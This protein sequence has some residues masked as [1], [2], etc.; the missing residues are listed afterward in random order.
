MN[1]PVSVDV[2]CVG[3]AVF[4]LVFAIDH[5]PFP[6]EKC[7]A[8]ALLT[9]G[10]GP[11]ANAAVTAARLG[12]RS[13]FAGYLGE[14]LFGEKHFQE[15]ERERVD[16]SLLV[17]GSTP[18]PLASIL[19]KP[20]GTRAVVNYR[21][22]TELVQPEK[23][24]LSAVSPKVILFDGHEH[25]ISLPLALEAKEQGILTVLDAGSV[26]QGTEELYT[27]VDYVVSSKTFALEHTNKDSADRA[28]EVL[29]KETSARLVITQGETGLSYWDSGTAMHM[30][31]FKVKASDTTG[32]GD[33]FHG[34]FAAA[35][36]QEMNW[37]DALRF[38]SAVAAL[39]C[40]RMGAR[41][42][43]PDKEEVERFLRSQK[44]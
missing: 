21:G 15:L 27:L 4:D 41:P 13:A 32:A 20:D 19:V 10:G 42:S 37:I 8:S 11:A 29:S 2:L 40:T 1:S 26:H 6:D 22:D 33:A 36:A 35:L 38:A 24:D 43:F 23:I 5:H 44:E 39:S 25:L 16:T 18:T 28:L 12:Y 30:P 9:C 31:A 14:D 7:F 3:Q 17:R 34:A